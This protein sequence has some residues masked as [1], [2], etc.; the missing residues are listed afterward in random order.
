MNC[1]KKTGRIRVRVLDRLE[2]VYWVDSGR[3]YAGTSTY[4]QTLITAQP[5]QP[6]RFA[7]NDGGETNELNINYR[8]DSETELLNRMPIGRSE[9]VGSK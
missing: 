4:S 1:G 8:P 9:V 2:K 6:L 3:Q 5:N 7:S